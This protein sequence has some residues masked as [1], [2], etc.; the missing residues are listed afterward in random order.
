MKVLELENISFSYDGGIQLLKDISFSLEKNEFLSIVGS[1]GCGKS[2]IIKLIA[3]IEKADSGTI[4][5][6]STGYMPQRDLLLPWRTVLQN[7]MLPVELNKKNREEGKKKAIE[8]LKKLHLDEYKDKL[9]QE[10]SGGMRQRVSFL[11]TL[12][13][14]ADIL[15][16]DEPFSALDAITKEYLQKWLL[17]TLK[18]FN[19]SIIFITH[20]INEALFLSDRI[21]VCKDK[22]LD[23]FAEFIVPKDKENNTDKIIEMKKEILHI[24]RG[25]N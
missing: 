17:D 13:T 24:I 23:S 3:G 12:L 4:K 20:D 19:K 8:Y 14:E 1:S 2:T 15:L 25:D 18:E 16:L 10:L 9:P 11:R 22:P 6:L 7:I 5:G 21:L